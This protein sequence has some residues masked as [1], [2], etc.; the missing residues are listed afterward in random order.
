MAERIFTI[1]HSTRSF[2]DFVSILDSFGIR[3]VA[4]VR[5][6]QRG[7]KAYSSLAKRW[8]GEASGAFFKRTATVSARL[9]GAARGAAR[10]RGV[11]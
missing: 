1:G 8:L 6:R 11:N 4:D 7:A 3:A 10:G 9:R 5:L 2:D